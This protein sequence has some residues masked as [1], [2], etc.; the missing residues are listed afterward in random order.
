MTHFDECMHPWLGKVMCVVLEIFVLV[1][2]L[3]LLI[4]LMGSTYEKVSE[5]SKAVVCMEKV[6]WITFNMKIIGLVPS[7]YAKLERNTRWFYVIQPNNTVDAGEGSEWSGVLA[8]VKN[9]IA[10]MERKFHSQ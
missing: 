3:N 2:M 4:A 8:A 1:I 6:R 10:K 5:S 7:W 9:E